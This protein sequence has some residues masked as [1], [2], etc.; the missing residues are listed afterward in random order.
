[1][2]EFRNERPA[3]FPVVI[4]FTT[5]EFRVRS[6]KANFTTFYHKEQIKYK[7]YGSLLKRLRL[8]K[9]L[10]AQANENIENE[11]S[12]HVIEDIPV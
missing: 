8:H 1:M 2:N 12:G 3:S 11:C 6:C 5:Q 4:Y 10:P 7:I 9:L